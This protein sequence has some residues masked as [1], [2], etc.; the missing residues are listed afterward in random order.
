MTFTGV[1]S[2]GWL[3]LVEPV[4][5]GRHI[6]SSRMIAIARRA[7]AIARLNSGIVGQQEALARLYDEEA[8]EVDKERYL[9]YVDKD[10]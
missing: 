10:S 4:Y 8:D 1:D 5:K 2:R 6:R 7:R 9:I 3:P